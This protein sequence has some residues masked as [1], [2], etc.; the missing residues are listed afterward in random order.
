MNAF[1]ATRPW[2]TNASSRQRQLQS[3]Q[4]NGGAGAWVSENRFS[5]PNIRTNSHTA[6]S[7]V[8]SVE[9]RVADTH[10]PNNIV[11]VLLHAVRPDEPALRHGLPWAP[12]VA[13]DSTVG[14]AGLGGT[15]AQHESGQTQ[16]A[17]QQRSGD[18]LFQVVGG[19]HG[20]LSFFVRRLGWR[21]PFGKYR[22]FRAL[23]IPTTFGWHPEAA[24]RGNTHASISIRVLSSLCGQR[25]LRFVAHARME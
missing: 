14:A 17:R 5:L 22:P 2:P 24:T 4:A 15:C 13:A 25:N 1:R 20:V 18:Q 10:V 6:I 16:A 7:T 19:V 12:L 11:N 3:G 9:V 21:S 8:G 23:P